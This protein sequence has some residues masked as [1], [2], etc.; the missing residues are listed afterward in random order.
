VFT[1]AMAEQKD[2]A[3]L[4]LSWADKSYSLDLKPAR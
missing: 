2:G 3:T 4:T 1:I